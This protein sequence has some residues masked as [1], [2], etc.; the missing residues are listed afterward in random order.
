MDIDD[1]NALVEGGDDLRTQLETAYQASVDANPDIVTPAGGDA[2]TVG[3][4]VG[5]DQAAN[6]ELVR[7]PVTGKFAPK[8]A[9]GAVGTSKPDATKPVGDKPDANAAPIDPTKAADKPVAP[10]PGW[11]PTSKR[12]YAALPDH[13]KADIAKREDEV[14]QG[15]AKLQSY[16]GLD[17]FVDMARKSGTSLPEAV[18]RYVAAEQLLEQDPIKGLKWLCQNY[19]VDPRRLVD[20]EQPQG[21]QQ[22]QQRQDQFRDPRVDQ[23]L[24]HV[25]QLINQPVKNQIVQFFADP[26]NVYAENVADDMTALIKSGQAKDLAEAYDKAC[27]ARPDIRS[28]LIEQ[29]TTD[30]AQQQ[31]QKAT[32]V[33]SNAR[34]AAKSI[35]GT[36][37]PGAS[38]APDLSEMSIREQL[39]RQFAAAT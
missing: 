8:V 3:T 5:G 12:D 14:N 26:K 39:E 38:N 18:Q 35:T 9:D 11:S 25:Q 30:A 20:G 4:D 31:R 1:D 23:I 17:P 6:R 36:P 21:G 10:P 32:T 22:P 7:D 24:P 37:L 28:L 13:I 2:P 19:K 33:A 27:W 16:K 29:Q 34:A 15:L